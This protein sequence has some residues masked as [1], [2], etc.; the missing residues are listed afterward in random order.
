MVKETIPDVIDRETGTA[1]TKKGRKQA[2]EK[3][4]RGKSS[5]RHANGRTKHAIVFKPNQ[6]ITNHCQDSEGADHFYFG[7][8]IVD[9]TVE[10]IPAK[11]N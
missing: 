5:L 2:R 11:I 7:T 3:K 4:L 9:A 1:V 10:I 8:E 6:D